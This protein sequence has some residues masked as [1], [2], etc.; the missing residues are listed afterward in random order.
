MFMGLNVIIHVMKIK[1][2]LIKAKKAT[3]ANANVEK[4]A[5]SRRGSNDYEY[6][7]NEMTYHDTY[8]GGTN[9]IGEEVVYEGSSE[10][11]IWGM[12]YY[13]VTLDQNLSEEAMDKAL[14]PALMKVG[15][16]DD[17]LPV[18]GPR[19]FINDNYEYTFNVD[20]DL[21]H[22][23]GVEEIRKDG[24]LIYRLRCTG[25]KII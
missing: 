9:F 20:G 24:A 23:D 8:F 14:R 18:R 17:I 2:F 13:G 7:D 21:E 6:S 5:A 22:F 19:R 3:Y 15:E 25:G 1:D 10:K 12:N 11:P 16:D 4:V